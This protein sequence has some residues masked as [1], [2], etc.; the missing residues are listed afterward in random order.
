MRPTRLR[1]D[2][3]TT[4]ELHDDDGYWMESKRRK[5]GHTDEGRRT[6]LGHQESAYGFAIFLLDTQPSRPC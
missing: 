3:T 1:L 2:C 4:T 6:G 5:R